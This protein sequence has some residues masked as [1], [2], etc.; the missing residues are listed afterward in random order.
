MRTAKELKETADLAKANQEPQKVTPREM[1]GWYG[2]ARRGSWITEQIVAHLARLDVVTFPSFAGAYIDA[3]IYIARRDDLKKLIGDDAAETEAAAA[4]ESATEASEP[5]SATRP[6]GP[7]HQ[8]SRLRAANTAPTSVA[9]N[10]TIEK[11]VT[12]MKMR[13]YSQLP[14]MTNPRELK[15]LISW[16]SIGEKLAAAQACTEVR[17]CMCEAPEVPET[18]SIFRVIQRVSEH[19]CVL[20]RGGDKRI[21]GIVTATD[22]SEQF[23]ALAEPF[24]V[25]GDIEN[26]LRHLIEKAGFDAEALSSVRDP[27][28]DGR[29]VEKVA[30]LTFGEYKRLVE[31]PENWKKLGLRIDRSEFVKELDKVREIRNDVMHFDPDGIGEE[32]LDSLRR[33][34]RFIE[35]L[36]DEASAAGCGGA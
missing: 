1:L 11:A 15:G 36:V 28:D 32:H 5:Q 24:L 4:Q 6:D 13:G 22:I 26:H 2:Y 16:R 27:D 30:D 10:D 17:H 8:I 31:N 12:L 20:V 35:G 29:R 25:L 34:S 9:P 7:M 23:H 19:D 21:K 18:E 14:V 3:P 33:F